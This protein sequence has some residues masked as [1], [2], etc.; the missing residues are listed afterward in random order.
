MAGM[1]R[2]A[3]KALS[4]FAINEARQRLIE[5]RE[6]YLKVMKGVIP[7][8]IC[9]HRHKITQLIQYRMADRNI[10]MVALTS[11]NRSI[12]LG[13]ANFAL[14]FIEAYLAIRGAIDNRIVRVMKSACML[15]GM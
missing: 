12:V 10:A 6:A 8:H 9:Y 1:L 11:G 15:S 7:I 4:E 13:H 2:S 5:Q 3:T 14:H